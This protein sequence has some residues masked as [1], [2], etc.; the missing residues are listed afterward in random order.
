MSDWLLTCL[1]YFLDFG[2][3]LTR[4]T[5]S[6]VDQEVGSDTVMTNLREHLLRSSKFDVALLIIGLLV[7]ISKI[8]WFVLGASLVFQILIN[9]W[10]WDFTF[11]VYDTNE[12]APT[13]EESYLHCDVVIWT[14]SV[15]TIIVWTVVIFMY[16]I[17]ILSVLIYDETTQKSIRYAQNAN[18][19]FLFLLFHVMF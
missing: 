17:Y 1:W 8:L 16:S 19:Y 3:V 13:P 4:A 10:V 15:Q 5:R 2:S 11:Y 14:F 6:M 12:V 9:Y 7:V 18:F